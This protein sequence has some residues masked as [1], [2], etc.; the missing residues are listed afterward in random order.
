M[1]VINNTIIG[2]RLDGL[3][4]GDPVFTRFGEGRVVSLYI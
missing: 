1:N 3:K 2:G 4:V